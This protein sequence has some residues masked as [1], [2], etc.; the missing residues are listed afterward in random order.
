MFFLDIINGI[1]TFFHNLFSKFSFDNLF[2]LLSGVVFGFILCF[3]IYFVLVLA[4]LKKEEKK[5]AI[6]SEKIDLAK[7]ERIIR[8]AK[9]QF[10]LES[11]NKTT[12]EKLKDLKDISWNLINAIAKEYFPESKYPIFELSID[13]IMRLNHYITNRIDSMF[14]GPVLRPIKK[15]KVSYIIKLLDFKKKI[16]ENKAVKA[17]N[18]LNKP[19]AITRSIINIFNPSYWFKKLV[20]ST[21]V[22]YMTNKMCG[23]VID[24][25]G[26]E[27]NKV[28]SKAVFNE[29][30]NLELDI[31]KQIREL[32]NLQEEEK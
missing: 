19:W 15:V 32:E 18:K 1:R 7:V 30:K 13:E 20:N 16:D 9:N 29:E 23:I 26:D 21:V 22:P 17:V 6:Q 10:L 3:L 4:S 11:S 12:G 24:V 31:E 28:Y 8:S 5:V 2:V 25:V 14:K 27:T